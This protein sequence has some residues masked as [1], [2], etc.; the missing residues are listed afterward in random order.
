M[1]FL[2]Q[3]LLKQEKKKYKVLQKE[4]DK[5]A[6]LMKDHEEGSE[7]EEEEPEEEVEEVGGDLE[8]I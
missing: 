5:M 3:G 8:I 4:V 6:K 7:E 1:I 2:F